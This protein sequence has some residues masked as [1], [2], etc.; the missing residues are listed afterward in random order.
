MWNQQIKYGAHIAL[1][2]VIEDV[3]RAC[4]VDKDD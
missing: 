2:K 4:E 3:P 1:S